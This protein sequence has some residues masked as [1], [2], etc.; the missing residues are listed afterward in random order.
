MALNNL[1]C[2][3]DVPLSNYSLIHVHKRQFGSFWG[4]IYKEL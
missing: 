1:L 4:P 2:C 3:A